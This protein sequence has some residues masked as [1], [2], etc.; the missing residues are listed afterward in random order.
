L[1]LSKASN[2]AK[3][4]RT[5]PKQPGHSKRATT[6][7]SIGQHQDVKICSQPATFAKSV[8]SSIIFRSKKY[9]P[10]MTEHIT[11]ITIKVFWKP[12]GQFIKSF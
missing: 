8:A 5:Q 4:D 10:N 1:V 9:L 6:S 2:A 12:I 7:P 11:L 3:L